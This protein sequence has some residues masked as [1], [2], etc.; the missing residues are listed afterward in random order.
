MRAKETRD[1]CVP[2]KAAASVTAEYSENVSRI[3]DD[4][5]E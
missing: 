4:Y 1:M 3:R 2:T 5:K